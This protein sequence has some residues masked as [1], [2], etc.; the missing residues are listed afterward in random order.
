MNVKDDIPAFGLY[1]EANTFPDIIHH[2]ALSVRAPLHDWRI[3]AHRHVQMSQLFMIHNGLVEARADGEQWELSG[4]HFL[5]V[6]ALC[7]HALTFR[8]GTVGS[9]FSFPIGTYQ[10]GGLNAADLLSALADPCMGPVSD[11]LE[12]VT[13]I[14]RSVAATDSA[15]RSQVAVSLTHA[16]LGLVAD[17]RVKNEKKTPAA[18]PSRIRSLDALI[19]ENA[20][21]GWSASDYAKAMA[22]ST[23]HL[24]RLCRLAAGLSA[25][26]YVERKIMGEACRLLAFTQL[27]VSEIGYRLGY[28]DPSYFSKRFRRAMDR[29]PLSYRALFTSRID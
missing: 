14:L 27:P 3:A 18:M 28:R 17:T 29:T 6:P 8:P 1:G 16:I 20:A 22:M 12:Q 4:G 23:G 5:Y 19:V 10:S 25:S 24:S 7:V 26:A 2:E 15:F 9:V 13:G 11:Q 21:R